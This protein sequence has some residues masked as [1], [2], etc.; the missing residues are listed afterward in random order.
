M[1]AELVTVGT[2]ILTGQIT[3]TMLNFSQKN[4]LNWE[5]MSFFKLP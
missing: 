1:K 3:N 5:L 2:E 4:L